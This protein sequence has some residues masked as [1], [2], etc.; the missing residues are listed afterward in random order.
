MFSTTLTSS[1]APPRQVITNEKPNWN[2]G[3]TALIL[4]THEQISSSESVLLDGWCMRRKVALVPESSDS[5]TQSPSVKYGAAL[6]I[7]SLREPL[8]TTATCRPSSF[9]NCT[10]G[11]KPGYKVGSPPPIRITERMPPSARLRKEA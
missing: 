9:R 2:T 3:L 5:R 8:L 10:I 1:R 4:L 7:C 6:R 11:T